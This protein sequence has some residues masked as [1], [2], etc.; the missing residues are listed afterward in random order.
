MRDAEITD[1]ECGG[2]ELDMTLDALKRSL[3][4]IGL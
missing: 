4:K 3:M 2:V 1:V